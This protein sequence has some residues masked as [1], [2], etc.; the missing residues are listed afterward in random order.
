MTEKQAQPNLDLIQMVQRARMQHDRDARPSQVSGVYWIESKPLQEGLPPTAH[1]GEW[2]IETTSSVV[3]A[4]WER[5]KAAT[6]AGELGYKS[7][8][9]TAPATHQVE[10]DARMI[11]VRTRDADDA[12]DVARVEARLR[13]LGVVPAR[14]ERI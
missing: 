14:Y 11:V 12:A 9:S 4:L 3:D 8:V 2:V 7:K 10:P 1:A 5:I 13:A 6:E